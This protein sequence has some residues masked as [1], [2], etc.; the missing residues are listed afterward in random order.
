[1]RLGLALLLG[2]A[3][4]LVALPAAVGG[5][6]YAVH[7]GDTAEPHGPEPGIIAVADT[8]NHRIL[9]FYSN[10]TFAH[11][12]G[13]YGPIGGASAYQ[14]RS[15]YG[16]FHSP[17]DA[18]VGPDGRIAV[19]D[20]GN[21][22]VQVFN[23]DGTFT[24]VFYFHW[25]DWPYD[26][27]FAPNGSIVVLWRDHT[28]VRG[29]G[30]H[31]ENRIQVFNADGTR[32]PGFG[33]YGDADPQS[34]PP[35]GVAVAP[36]GRIAV[37]YYADRIQ[38]YHPNGTLALAFGSYGVGPGQFRSPS[39]VAVA[40]DGRIAVADTGNDRIQVFHPNGTLALAFGS[41][42]VGPGQFRSPSG[43]AVA[44]DGRIA[45]ADTGNDRIQ[46]FHPNGTPASAL[47]SVPDAGWSYTA[48]PKVAVAPDGKIVVADA[49]NHR[50]HVYHPNGTLASAFG[51]FS[52]GSGQIQDMKD[53][54]V[55]PDGKI[56]VAD[57][58]HS[59]GLARRIQV[60]NADGTPDTG[61]G[62]R[63]DGT[64]HLRL[65]S[66][67]PCYVRS[68][69]TP[70][71]I[72]AIAVAPDGKIML[73]YNRGS[74][75]YSPDYH[76]RVLNADGSCDRDFGLDFYSTARSV[77][78]NAIAIASDGK[79]LVAYRD[80]THAGVGFPRYENRIQVFNA[81][82]TRAAP[83]GIPTH[84]G[85][86]SHAWNALD[87]A[88]ASDGKIVVADTRN[89][90]INVINADGTLA[91]DFATFGDLFR[92]GPSLSSMAVAPDGKIVT[93][94]DY[95]DHIQV[96]HP[97][98]TRAL[99]FLSSLT[100]EP[101][102]AGAA[103]DGHRPDGAP[104]LDF[105]TSRDAA[106][107]DVAVAPDGRIVAVDAYN[108][109]ILVRNA[110]VTP[111][112]YIGSFGAG[113]GQ[114]DHPSGVA[115]APDGRI[116]VADTGNHRVQVLYPNGAHS[117]DFGSRGNGTG[118]FDYPSGVAVAPDGRIV[119]ADTGNHR[120]QA[121][122]ADGTPALVIGSTGN[123]SGQF[124]Y[125][126]SVAVAPDGRIVVADTG[127][128]VQVFHP[129]G[130]F[131]LGWYVG[132]VG[133]EGRP[134]PLANV[135]V[136]PDGMIVVAAD[137]HPGQHSPYGVGVFHP[138]G[139]RAFDF[140]SYYGS[141]RYGG[142]PTGVAVAPDGR[143]LVAAGNLWGFDADGTPSF[144]LGGRGGSNEPSGVAVAPDGK[145]AVSDH[146]SHRIRVLDADGALVRTIGS[147]GSGTGQLQYPQDVDIGG[148]DGRIA[149]VDGRAL[150]W[151]NPDR[152]QV[153]HPNGTFAFSIGPHDVDDEAAGPFYPSDVAVA[154]DGRIVAAYN[155][156]YTVGGPW[157]PIDPHVRVFDADGT[158]SFAFRPP[159]DGLPCSLHGVDVAPDGRI[160]LATSANC[161]GGGSRSSIQAYHPNGTFDTTIKSGPYWDVAVAPDGWIA[162]V[163]YVGYRANYR[164]NIQVFDSS[165]LD[166]SNIGTKGAG[167]GQFSWVVP[168][169]AVAPD[170]RIVVADNSNDRIQVFQRDGT[171]DRI[172]GS[173]NLGFA[174]G[175]GPLRSPAGVA[176]GPIPPPVVVEPPPPFNGTGP[177]T[178][179]NG[180]APP[181]PVVVEPPPPFNGTG[182][183]QAPPPPA[184][185]GQ[186]GGIGTPGFAGVGATPQLVIDVARL[187][188]PGDSQISGDPNASTATFPPRETAVVVPFV[189]VTFPPSV[190]AS[191]VPADGLLALNV[192]A[193]APP[194]E[195]VQR[196]LAYEGSGRVVPQRIVEVG[197]SSGRGGSGRVAFDQPVRIVLE[198]QA[199]GRAFYIQGAGGAITPIDAAC[200][201]DDTARVHRQLGGSGECQIDS[202][203]GGDKIIYTYHLTRFG[204]VVS[205][206][207]A[208]PPVVHTCSARLGTP[209]LDVSASL[210][211]QSSPVQQALIN[212]GSLPFARVEL[213]ATPWYVD[214]DGSAPPAADHPS[215]P[216]SISEVLFEDVDFGHVTT[217]VNGTVVARGL[218]GGDAVPLSFVANLTPYDEVQGSALVQYVT[219]LAQC[220]R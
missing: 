26:V 67:Y 48:P 45:V 35:S 33:L 61:F 181:P 18:A 7:G 146:H 192:S 95:T 94:G 10:G 81:D 69:D 120:V 219:Y 32:T 38:V 156:D 119:V 99:A 57:L 93:A 214:W 127:N 191:R 197:G 78:V 217:A 17:S 211:E 24:N 64:A 40:P 168:D 205:E 116:V 73:A 113:P 70:Q 83:P 66:N 218:G 216:S 145:I 133:G 88:V 1:M 112:F 37:S 29:S 155:N 122:D 23:A 84:A 60:F 147:F 213:E 46:V 3:A 129:N 204:T 14:Y 126:Y 140:Q 19:V 196:A 104:T 171:L 27:A 98:G 141:P 53:I 161:L 131:D 172:L 202:D 101:D 138:N 59:S 85:G 142:T 54:A 5:G 76:I 121:F 2:I 175:A 179:P 22:R 87:I 107:F 15:G 184:V 199:G 130:T 89:R 201:A 123:R 9:V 20:S 51:S 21:Q 210:G 71:P 56:V 91:R 110:N 28:Y 74:S 182:P 207:G 160:V 4:G 148:P 47:G 158:F 36:D 154:P 188:G 212:S 162:A 55:A 39:G 12:F 135:A 189:E 80:T 43:V 34:G 208:P 203:D 170:G 100:W 97:N 159:P 62:P 72:Y 185:A 30:A 195:Q 86:P 173:S 193:E 44:P 125:P 6:A 31:Y 143:I 114:F 58:P 139:T 149:V 49:D 174:A 90:R 132:E 153:F 198:G 151:A 190:T 136:A 200:A 41:Y 8:D 42:G 111:A 115:V 106:S 103:G 13:S 79:I 109:R 166:H 16:Q 65:I 178:A 209:N 124:D 177:P 82:G 176:I 92:G 187:A 183:P 68:Y 52:E 134:I 220:S 152:I 157:G 144:A 11:S 167:A 180:T 105:A 150:F 165:G 108:H 206:S 163:N 102:T 169:I 117:F 137:M 194:D 215:L 128:G 164:A 50:I 75:S 63:G 186:G 118:Q 25:L 96:F 77:Y